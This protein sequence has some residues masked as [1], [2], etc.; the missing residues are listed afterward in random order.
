M[1]CPH[2]RPLSLKYRNIFNQKLVLGEGRKK[3]INGF[4]FFF[5]YKKASSGKLPLSFFFDKR[6]RGPGGEGKCLPAFFKL[7]EWLY[8][9][10]VTGSILTAPLSA[11]AAS[12][13]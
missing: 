1:Q 3:R 10:Q 8:S 7:N 6:E 13:P 5:N 9:S 4:L 11:E 2:P 12:S